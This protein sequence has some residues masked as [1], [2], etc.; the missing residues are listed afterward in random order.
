MKYYKLKILM[1]LGLLSMFSCE[2]YLDVAPES[3]LSQEE[4]FSNFDNA[5]GF[6]E[7]M[8]AM[9]CDYG[10]AGHTFQD[11]LFGD[12]S[13]SIPVWKSSSKVDLGQLG[14]WQNGSL[15]Y[16]GVNKRFPGGN[17]NE[18]TSAAQATARHRVWEGSMKGIRKANIVIESEYLMV[19]L[20]QEEKNV[21]LGQAYFFRAYFHNEVMKFWGRFP[22]INEVFYGEVTIQRPETYRESALAVNEDYKKAIELL[23]LNWDN[24]SYGQK[25][26]G[27]NELRV[28]KGAAYAFQGK[29]LLLA[30]SPLMFAN[31]KAGMDTYKYDTELAAMAVDAFAGV[32]NLVD[33]GIY[34]FASADKIEEVF[35][36]TSTPGTFP[37]L[38]PGAKELIFSAPGGNNI[39]NQRFMSA[40]I[41]NTV[42]N[43]GA[44]GMHPPTHNYIHYNFGMANGLSIEDDLKGPNTYNPNRPFDNR[45]PRFYKYIAYDREPVGTKAT[46]PTQH[47]Q[48]QFYTGGAHRQNSLS[49]TGYGFK[50]FFPIVN[51]EYHSKWNPI[52]GDYMGMRIAMRVTDVYLMYAEALHVSLGATS[53]PASYSLTAEQVINKI[54]NRAGLVNISSNVVGDSNKFMDELRRERTVE[55]CFE[56]HRWVDIRRWGVAHLDRYKTK[57]EL[58]FD[59]AWTSFEEKVLR[60]RVC[61]YPKHYWLPFKA[62]QTQ[63]YAGFPQNPGW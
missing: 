46:I 28:T 63:F 22:H 16:L 5:Q 14:F 59:K 54:R 41:P 1:I 19:G 52:I 47:K 33:Q 57:T 39:A 11:Y 4:V 21:I 36:K 42:G 15:S 61:E 55:L 58:V 51:G 31:N 34:N 30:A 3:V 45:D 23:P 38:S 10:T 62:N 8:Y 37:A 12:Q 43:V 24:E 18:N 60:I 17:G 48:W 44:S 9:V 29:N 2:S 27:Q 49:T 35:W 13:F 25:T 56:A 40:G 7:E 50:K 26:L 6:V 32:L 53:A 20:S